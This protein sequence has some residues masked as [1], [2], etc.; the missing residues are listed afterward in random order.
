MPGHLLG[1]LPAGTVIGQSPQREHRD[2]HRCHHVS[3]VA[4]APNLDQSG[5]VPC[6]GLCA[7]HPGMDREQRRPGHAV[8]QSRPGH[9]PQ[10]VGTHRKP[11]V[12][13][14][15][16][17]PKGEDLP[18]RQFQPSGHGQESHLR[19]RELHARECRCPKG[20]YA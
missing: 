8:L 11:L 3:V 16:P 13:G 7:L 10:R 2:V 18:L 1:S 19:A 5:I 15:N 14:S 12:E 17:T 6:G 4:R 20:D 9:L